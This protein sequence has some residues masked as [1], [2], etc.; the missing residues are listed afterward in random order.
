[1]NHEATKSTRNKEDRIKKGIVDTLQF[2]VGG[3]FLNDTQNGQKMVFSP[4]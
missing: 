2:G 3:S 4:G 1:M